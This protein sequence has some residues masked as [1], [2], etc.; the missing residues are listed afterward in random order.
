MLKNRIITTLLYDE[1]L[2]CVKPV[3]FGR[4]YR[5]LGPLMQY[6][7]NFD[8]RQIDELI[9]LDI[10][11]TETNRKPSVK[12]IEQFTSLCYMPVCIGGGIRTLDN[13]SELLNNGADKV[14]IG[15]YLYKD[16]SNSYK[17][18]ETAANKFGSQAIV[19]AINVNGDKGNFWTRDG[20]KYIGWIN[21]NPAPLLSKEL[22]NAGAGEIFLTDVTKDGTLSGYNLDLISSVAHA[23]GIPVIANGGCGSPDDMVAAIRAGAKELC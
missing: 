10:T 3:G 18:I 20:Y 12:E 14:V 2:Q 9:L 4:P 23:V 6:I 7:R 21:E 16:K 13:I 19:A 22:E 11:A 5:R 8:N 15:N 1:T 17:F